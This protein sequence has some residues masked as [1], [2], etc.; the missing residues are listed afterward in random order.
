MSNNSFLISEATQ[1]NW[2]RLSYNYAAKLTS[3]ANKSKSDKYIIPDNYICGEYLN[4]IVSM[5]KSSAYS[6]K[7]IFTHLCQ[8]KLLQLNGNSNVTKFLLEYPQNSNVNIHIPDEVLLDVNSDWL[9]FLYQ[10]HT[11]EGKRNLKGMYYTNKAVVDRMLMDVKLGDG[12]TFLDPCCGTGAFLMNVQANTLSQLYGVDNDE[13][14]VMI[15]KANLIALYPNDDTYPKVYCDDFL[16]DSLFTLN[17][18]VG[19]QFDFIY[20]NPPWGISK[21]NSYTDDI[22]RS[23]E[24]SSMFFVKAFKKLKNGGMMAF[25]MPSA[26]L[27]VNMHSDFR[28]FV[29]NKTKIEKVAIFKE[30]FN[31]VYT[32]FFSIH[33]AKSVQDG[34]Q[35]YSV[36]N[37]NQLIN[38]SFD[39]S[40]YQTDIPLCNTDK[41]DILKIIDSKG[42]YS[43]ADSVWALGIVTG[44]NK[45]KLKSCRLNNEYESIYTGKDIGKYCLTTPSHYILYNRAQLQQCAKDEIYRCSEKL[46]YRFI[47]KSL[48]FAY[49]NSSSLFLNS[50]NIL[51]PKI[52]GMTIKTVLAF[53]N[54]DLF[55]YYYQKK[56]SDI[57]VLKSNLNAIPFPKITPALDAE[58]TSIVD[59]VLA[60]DYKKI[61]DIDR[62]IFDF[63]DITLKMRTDIKNELYGDITTRAETTNR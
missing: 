39:V 18:L 15:A 17:S 19:T 6:T 22:I 26:L 37:G 61:E 44:D 63:Y 4:D 48:C 21:E 3:R 11:P 29:L 36:E 41:N 53:L 43:L 8:Q 58:I 40:Q 33:V 20:T 2:S 35:S 59:A 7:D 62:L 14:A 34:I 24:R 57:K 50:A 42:V 27:K 10:A 52:E 28:S 5:I 13:I 55:A 30:R 46:V 54:S 51:I 1:R 60:G 23:K 45:N 12:C 31:G 32:D 56:F 38:I 47:S 9:G 49:D 25:L 16:E